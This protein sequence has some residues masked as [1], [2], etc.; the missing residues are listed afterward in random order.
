M[1]LPFVKMHGLGNDFV[2]LDGR[3][4]PLSLTEETVRAVADR[5]TGVGCDQLIVMERRRD[6]RADVFMRIRNPD[7]SEAGACGNA[8]RCV[9]ALLMRE[10]GRDSVVIETVA[11]L[12]PSEAAGDLVTVDMGPA[13]LDWAE[14]PLAEPMDTL[15]LP[16][17][18]G[19]YGGPCAVSMGNP[20]VVFFVPDT[21][22]VDLAAL[23]PLV[24]R[25]PLFPERTNV[26]FV[27]V[28]SPHRLRMR[29]WERSAGITRACGSG[30]CAVL[31][32]A[33]RRGLAARRAEVALDGGSLWL[34]WRDDGHV[35]MTGPVATSFNGVLAPDLL[36]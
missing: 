15:T 11:G 32:A 16:V 9:A 25:H 12:L 19:P 30:A 2:V 20:H 5:R 14:I 1:S 36:R 31:V 29:V 21:A 33:A 27:T 34:E 28:E 24:E 23:G 6:R 3:H 8:T 13:R 35:L 4:F 17:E 26:E 22:A 10:S 18:A 7:G